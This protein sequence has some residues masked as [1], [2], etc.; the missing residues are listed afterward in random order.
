M[1]KITNAFIFLFL[2]A[3]AAMAQVP[4]YFNTNTAGG[5]NSWPYNN[6]TTARRI[7]F[8]IPPN[9]L[10]AV[11]AG[12]NIVK[13][14]FQAGGNATITYPILNV[15]LKQA[16]ASQT[17]L[18]GTTGGPMESGMTS[19]FAGANVPITTTT[20]NWFNITLTTPFLY[21]PAFP[22]IVEIEH[23]AS[24]GPGPTIYQ[25]GNI[26]GP[27]WGRQWADYNSNSITLP[28]GTERVNFGIDVLPA[29]PCTVTP[30]ANTAVG[31][32]VAVCPNASALIGLATT[33]SFGGI[34][35][36][37]QSS[38]VSAVGPFTAISGATTNVLSTSGITM[39]TWYNAVVTCTNAAGSITTA[40]ASG[41]PHQNI[42]KSAKY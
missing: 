7:Q 38:T 40:V 11:T 19:V 17:G 18:T 9:N 16:P 31:P 6:F 10:G 39:P 22:L 12:N 21:D 32:T 14:Y 35:Y 24:A 5:A 42:N 34:T 28:G 26:P 23:N 8:F 25:S 27:G 41:Q 1:R 37:W 36:Q 4:Q 2:L 30:A 3:G 29:I 33:Y 20:G 15:K 13:I